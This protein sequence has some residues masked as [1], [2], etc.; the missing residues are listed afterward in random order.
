MSKTFTLTE[1]KTILT[2]IMAGKNPAEFI[3]KI[4][5]A[6][7]GGA[8]AV[9][10]DLFDLA[11]EFRNRAAFAEIINASVLPTMFIYY[12]N[13]QSYPDPGDEARQEILLEAA[14][15]GAAMID[16]I[17]DLYDPS[18][19]EITHNLE[20]IERQKALIERIHQLGS[21]VIIS[22]HPSRAMSAEA[23]LAQLKSFAERNA[24]VVKIVTTANTDAEFVEAIRTTML[25]HRKMKTPFVHLCSGTYGRLHRMTGLS[26][27]VA[28]TFAVNHYDHYKY[29]QPAL[30]ALKAVQENTHWHIASHA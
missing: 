19:D 23:V 14:A 15:A 11:P 29:P 26:L 30:S 1:Q 18:P 28:I 20:A 27:G 3:A 8:R 24:D 7:F 4:R 9:A 5:E 12:R 10:V 21:Q 17:G 25:L 22:S 6:E 13:V 16:V 2:A